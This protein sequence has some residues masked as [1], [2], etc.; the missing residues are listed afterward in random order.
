MPVEERAKLL[1][2]AANT[3]RRSWRELGIPTMLPFLLCREN[4]LRGQTD[5]GS[6][7]EKLIAN[8]IVGLVVDEISR[9]AD[10]LSYRGGPIYLALSGGGFRAILFHLGVLRW[11]HDNDCLNSVKKVTSVSGGS[12][13]AA[14]LSLNWRRYTGNDK[15][16]ESVAEELIGFTQADVRGRIIRRWLLGTLLHSA[17]FWPYDFREWYLEIAVSLVRRS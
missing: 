12:I 10:G 17:H 8:A 1:D 5:A 3:Y 16:F 14:H 13:L 6:E 4:L 9:V 2:K 15:D 7:A 11:L